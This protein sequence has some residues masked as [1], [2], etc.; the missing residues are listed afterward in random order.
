[1]L[2]IINSKYRN[3]IIA[4]ISDEDFNFSILNLKNLEIIRL[5]C[6]MYSF[7]LSLLL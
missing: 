7:A 2:L 4:H 1:M 5:I 6:S 3:E